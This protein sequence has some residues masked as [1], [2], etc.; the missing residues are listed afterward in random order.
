MVPKPGNSTSRHQAKDPHVSERI[1]NLDMR[2]G[3][4]GKSS[5][6]YFPDMLV[7]GVNPQIYALALFSYR[8]SIV[9]FF[10]TLSQSESKSGVDRSAFPRV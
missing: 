5:V 4:A 1:Q 7:G 9:L 6:S 2:S 8:C 10:L 3:G